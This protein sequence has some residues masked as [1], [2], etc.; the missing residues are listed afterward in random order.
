MAEN[1]QLS[2]EEKL[3]KVIQQ[4]GEPAEEATAAATPASDAAPEAT[5]DVAAETK[6]AEEA[7]PTTKSLRLATK[8]PESSTDAAPEPSVRIGSAEPTFFERKRPVLRPGIATVNRCLVGVIVLM[9][10]FA[11]IEIWANIQ[12]VETHHGFVPDA[13]DRIV[14]RSGTLI[15]LPPIENVLDSFQ[16]KPIFS[17]LEGRE[18]EETP[19]E[20]IPNWEAYARDNVNLIGTSMFAGEGQPGQREAILVDSKTGKMHFLQVGQTVVLDNQE[21]ELK[22]IESDNVVLSDGAKDIVLK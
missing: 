21:L 14:S 9:L 16:R 8:A 19:R 7:A 4:D 10:L 6:P 11:I 22:R 15:Q 13:T 18:G 20:R 5:V 17:R 1:E 2:P 12:P 3:L